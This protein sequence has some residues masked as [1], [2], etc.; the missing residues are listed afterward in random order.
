[1]R[2]WRDN[3]LIP[4]IDKQCLLLSDSYSGQ[5]DP[6]IYEDIK[7][8]SIERIMIPRNTTCDIQPLDGYFNRQMK[9]FIKRLYHHVALEQLDINLC[10][11]N[12]IIKLISLIHN[13]LSSPVFKKMIQYSWFAS[14]YTSVNPS[15]FQNVLQVCFPQ[16]AS[17]E[18]CEGRNCIGTAFINYAICSK[19]LCFDHFF[20]KYYFHRKK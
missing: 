20:V 13:Q 2:Y 12:N 15:P 14:H 18:Q 19:K 11:R 5:N 1:M 4:S 8:K 9:N 7:S 6:K 16:I 3:C 17:I 10:E